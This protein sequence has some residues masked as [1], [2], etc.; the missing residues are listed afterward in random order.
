MSAAL[1]ALMKS[2]SGFIA[3]NVAR[4][5]GTILCSSGEEEGDTFAVHSLR[6]LPAKSLTKPFG[7]DMV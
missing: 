4:V 6:A 2:V 7:A 3:N 5:G 1:A